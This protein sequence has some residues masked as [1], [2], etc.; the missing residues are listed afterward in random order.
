[1]QIRMTEI[2]N[3]SGV[4]WHTFCTCRLASTGTH[5]RTLNPYT[6]PMDVELYFFLFPSFSYFLFYFKNKVIKIEL[7]SVEGKK[8][9]FLME[10]GYFK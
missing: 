10:I 9:F 1:M 5:D 4:W 3:I 8:K 7:H 2:Y 6:Y